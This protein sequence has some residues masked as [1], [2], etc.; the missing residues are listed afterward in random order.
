M[1]DARQRLQLMRMQC[2]DEPNWPMRSF[3]AETNERDEP[4]DWRCE[5][6]G[7]CQLSHAHGCRDL[8]LSAIWHNLDLMVKFLNVVRTAGL[9][10]TGTMRLEMLWSPREFASL[11]ELDTPFG[12]GIENA[13]R[14]EWLRTET[15]GDFRVDLWNTGEERE[16]KSQLAYRLCWLDK[17]RAR[18]IAEERGEVDLPN[19]QV[20]EV[21][22]AGE[23]FYPG[24]SMSID[25][26]YALGTLIGF[27]SAK[28]GDVED[29]FF[30]DYTERQL[31]FAEE[32]GEELSVWCADLETTDEE[33]LDRLT[34]E[35]DSRLA[36][37][38][39]PGDEVP[40]NLMQHFSRLSI[41]LKALEGSAGDGDL[42]AN[43]R[44][45]RNRIQNAYGLETIR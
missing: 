8:L 29:D 23:R 2:A 19:D 12:P 10:L 15:H 25:G 44:T 41:E 26:D 42:R 43:V 4:V 35:L 6:C 9:D 33:R 21:V 18:E 37:L 3:A 28:P 27:L 24:L 16:G 30:K 7:F 5:H 36:E 14:L 34:S 40:P 22:F 38:P 45:Q 17:Q 1:P 11:K 31:K 20:W 13:G 32:H 39:T